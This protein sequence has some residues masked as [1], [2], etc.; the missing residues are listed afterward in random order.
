MSFFP[1]LSSSLPF[2][3][4]FFFFRR[5]HLISLFVSSFFFLFFFLTV[6]FIIFFFS[7]SSFARFV[8]QF[9]F[10]LSHFDFSKRQFDLFIY[11]F[12]YYYYYYYYYYFWSIIP[13]LAPFDFVHYFLSFRSSFQNN[14]K[15]KTDFFLSCEN[16]MSTYFFFY[17]HIRKHTNIDM[18]GY[19]FCTYI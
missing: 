9:V 4:S 7:S 1:I 16:A 19:K 2:V 14:E 12:I 15:C 6:S 8:F 18:N 11:L 13:F 10:I 3:L 5:N 17:R